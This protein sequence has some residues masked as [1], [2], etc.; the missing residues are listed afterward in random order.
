MYHLHTR[1][2]T[3]FSKQTAVD[4]VQYIARIGKY[5]KRGDIVRTF[6]SLYLPSWVDRQRAEDF[7]KQADSSDMRVNGRRL[8]SIDIAIPRILAVGQQN[9]LTE[10]FV[11]SLSALST[12]RQSSD[13]LT[14]T[15]AIHE[16]IR[17][18]DHL[19]GRLPNPHAHILLSTSIVDGVNRIKNKWF[20]RANSKDLSNSGSPRSVFIGTKRWL[21]Q[22]RQEWAQLANRALQEAGLTLRLDHR[23][24]ADRGLLIKPTVHVGPKGMYLAQMGILSDQIRR[25]LQYQEFNARLLKQ[26]T[27]HQEFQAKVRLRRRTLEAREDSL[28]QSLYIATREL[29]NELTSHP[30]MA[31]VPE[32]SGAASILV[33][34]SDW[35]ASN[36]GSLSL[37]LSEIAEKMALILGPR[38]TQMRCKE[39]YLFV[40][41][42]DAS[43]IALNSVLIATDADDLDSI[44]NFVDMVSRMLLGKV[45][46]FVQPDA[47]EMATAAFEA[48]GIDAVICQIGTRTKNFF[49]KRMA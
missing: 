22:V 31:P 30:L 25:N 28:R 45:R 29:E 12:G 41:S 1:R 8:F 20:R 32:L 43:V 37:P 47:Q 33:L 46:V 9:A 13:R 27:E 26:Q 15:Y 36:M 14:V 21:M 38:W 16:G 40:G 17:K 19:T 39:R 24:H 4:S 44:A 34:P 42:N 7:W 48:A 2:V 18:D 49:L 6:A 3:K 5:A 35:P 11:E 23:S 10:A